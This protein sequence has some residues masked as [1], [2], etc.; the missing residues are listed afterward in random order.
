MYIEG[1]IISIKKSRY[2]SLDTEVWLAIPLCNVEMPSDLGAEN[3]KYMVFLHFRY[4]RFCFKY[5][6]CISF[7]LHNFQSYFMFNHKISW[8]PNSSLLSIILLSTSLHLPDSSNVTI[9]LLIF[10]WNPLV[11]V[12]PFLRTVL[13]VFIIHIHFRLLWRCLYILL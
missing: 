5:Y 4:P 2:F 6:L 1:G 3:A 7:S 11:I 12:Y 13:V 10:R 9:G 8:F